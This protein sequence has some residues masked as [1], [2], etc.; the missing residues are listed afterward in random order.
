MKII[1]EGGLKIKHLLVKKD[2]WG[3]VPCQRPQCTACTEDKPQPG[4]CRERSIVYKNFCNPCQSEGKVVS[5][6]GETSRSM[7]EQNKEHWEDAASK[8]SNSHMRTHFSQH[9]PDL[10]HQVTDHS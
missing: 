7:A 2:P 1:E 10:L 5:Y 9:H 8:E 4:V 6:L 3:A